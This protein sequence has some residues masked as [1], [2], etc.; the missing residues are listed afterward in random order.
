M[1]SRA[2][3]ADVVGTD[4]DA[5]GPAL[6]AGDLP[7]A[8]Y[9]LGK[10][11]LPLAAV[12]ADLTGNVVG[13]DVDE[14]VVESVNRGDTHVDGEPGL[15]ELVAD[16][17]G[18][19][20]LRATADP[21][22]A[23][24]RARIHVVIV[25]TLLSRE[26]E[27]DLSHLQAAIEAVGAGLSPGDLVC[28]ESTVP[29]G[30][31][32]DVLAP[33]LGD[34]SGLDRDEFGLAFCPER[35]ASGRALQD[36]RGAYPK[37]VGGIDDRSTRAAVAV[38]D[39]V[40]DN[41]VVTVPDATTAECVKVFEGLYR[42]VN[43]ALANELATLGD[44][45]G[46]DVR[47]AIETANTQPYCEIHDPGP[48]VGGHCIPY[49]PYFVIDGCQTGTPLLRTA[50]EVN[51]SMPA[52]TAALTC[53]ELLAA[54]RDTAD[55]S[56]AILGVAYRPGVDE[57]RESPGLV[58]ADILTDQVADVYAVDP[59]VDEHAHDHPVLSVDC[60]Q[61]T[62]LDALVLVTPHEAFE[63][64]DWDALATDTVVI[65]GRDAL[66]DGRRND[67]VTTLGDGR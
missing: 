43:I 12:F 46:V 44:E 14:A 17:V 52:Y 3:T 35:T 58:I 39:E 27:P 8:V 47:A 32:R 67:S 26:R 42:D 40:T 56:V 31:C 25:P 49:Y 1:T 11:G 20:A 55:A 38:Y 13:A 28:I 21:S 33:A 63:R 34:A 30:T 60:L 10:M 16:T 51:E 65:D 59:V 53:S 64:L 50:R 29:P 6:R 5:I 4:P 57:T 54:G 37:V 9:G 19:D 48:G 2:P 18:R 36:I 41:E 66:E 61:D 15:R 45:L 22:A 62:D 7:V 23:A 24:R